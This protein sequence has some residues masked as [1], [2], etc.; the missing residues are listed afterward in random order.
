MYEDNLWL[1]CFWK[2]LKLYVVFWY[3]IEIFLGNEMYDILINKWNKELF[4]KIYFDL[5]G[6]LY[7][8]IIMIMFKY[9][10]II[11]RNNFW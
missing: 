3:E 11:L 6:N 7:W 2:L 9:K 1:N 5:M 4:E 8:F 10:G